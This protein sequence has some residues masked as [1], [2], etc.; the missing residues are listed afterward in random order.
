MEFA[1]KVYAV[2]AGMN[3][4]VGSVVL[5]SSKT[6]GLRSTIAPAV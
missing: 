6:V 1:G 3:A 5:P 2:A 4:K